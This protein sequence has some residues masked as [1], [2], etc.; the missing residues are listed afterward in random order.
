MAQAALGQQSAYAVIQ[1]AGGKH[2]DPSK[3]FGEQIAQGS[4]ASDDASV[5]KA[6]DELVAGVT[7]PLG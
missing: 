6:L 2:W 4:I 5:Q 7:A 3:S 1:K